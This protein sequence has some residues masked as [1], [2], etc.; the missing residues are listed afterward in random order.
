MIFKNHDFSNPGFRGSAML[1]IPRGVG[2]RTP[3]LEVHP[4]HAYT[5]SSQP[6]VS[7]AS[8]FFSMSLVIVHASL[9]HVITERMQMFGNSNFKSSLTSCHL[10]VNLLNLFSASSLHAVVVLC[11]FCA[12]H[13]MFASNSLP[14]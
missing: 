14:R 8:S 5:S 4:D 11:L 6:S 12:S 7:Q 9:P 13:L 1:S 2:S 10:N 3:Q